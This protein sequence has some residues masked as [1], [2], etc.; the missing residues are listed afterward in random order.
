MNAPAAGPACAARDLR[1]RYRGA[2]EAALR[3]VGLEVPVGS[4]AAILGPNGAGKST[5][6]RLL[7]GILSPA[8]GE[9]RLLGRDPRTW[10]RR[11]LAR[12][13]AVVSQGPPPDLPLR[14]VEFV[15]MG[16]NPWLRPWEAARP[17][18]RR[19]VERAL[20]RTRLRELAERPIGAVSGG[21]LQRAKLARALAQE[22][23][24]LLLDEPTAHLDLGEE[25]RIFQ[26]VDALVGEGMTAVT[27]TH[28]L[29]MAV[30]YADRMAF[31]AAGRVL[32]EGPPEAVFR[33]DV[34]ERAFGWPV[35]VVDLGPLGRHAVPLLGGEEPRREAS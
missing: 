20:G 32:A 11:A 34:V 5:L 21:E 22:P 13:V 33:P 7:L 18:D 23:E 10:G 4:H 1:F 26:L 19:A 8:G 17:R 25:V 9:V 15:A 31:L 16:R 14:V 24:V 35:E 30:R 6:L 28:N 3:G 2:T 29:G 27:V 12:R